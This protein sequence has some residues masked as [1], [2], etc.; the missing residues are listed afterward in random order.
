MI[1]EMVVKT[2]IPKVFPP[3]LESLEVSRRF[4]IPE[5]KETNINGTA[6][7]LAF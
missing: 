2:Y 7:V 1:A 4:D 5:I 3:I 6:K